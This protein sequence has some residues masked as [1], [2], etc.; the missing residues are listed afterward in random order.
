MHHTQNSDLPEEFFE[1]EMSQSSVAQFLYK[2]EHI[3]QC[4]ALA[5]QITC[6]MVEPYLQPFTSIQAHQLVTLNLRKIFHLRNKC[7]K[8]TSC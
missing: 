6:Q 1:Y 2:V 5:E 7:N 8:H 4:I 3:N